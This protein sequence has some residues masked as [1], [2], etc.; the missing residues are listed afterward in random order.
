MKS[1]E[2][3]GGSPAGWK[4]EDGKL[5]FPT[6]KGIAMV[7]P[8][9]IQRNSQPPPVLVEEAFVDGRPFVPRELLP[10]GGRRF[11][12]RYTGLSFVSPARMRFAYRLEGFDQQ[13]ID[14]G[15]ER[16]AY[17]TNLPA[18]DY[19]F[20]VRAAN[21]DGVW[22]KSEASFDFTLQP[23]FYQ[24]ALFYALCGLLIA[25]AGIGFY[26][27]RTRQLRERQRVL[28]VKIDEAVAHIKTLR[29]L[30]PICASCK[31]IRDDG[32]YWNQIEQYVHEHTEAEFS[33]GICPDCMKKLYPDYI[34]AIHARKE[35]GGPIL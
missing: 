8:G 26:L 29:G 30:L 14:A 2:C 3:N 13:W 28:E 27:L 23:H 9:N 25:A 10:P 20:L 11:E 4:T 5:W 32:G 31:R 33:H 16:A 21:N 1:R 19:R 12:F 35:K 15:N 6:L 34:A 18:G 17:Y 7:E 22:S 24:T